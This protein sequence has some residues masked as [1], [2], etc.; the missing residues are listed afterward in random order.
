MSFD[1]QFLTMMPSTMSMYAFV[2]FDN[3][4]EPTYSTSATSIRC[5]MEYDHKSMQDM[6]SNEMVP[7]ATAYLGYDSIISSLSKFVL[8][9]GSTGIVL[10]IEQAW[11]ETGIH[12]NVVRFGAG[13]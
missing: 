1:T 4:G 6:N 13:G 3:Y 12:H 8:P 2:S 11:D 7:T 9:D 10:S 5:R